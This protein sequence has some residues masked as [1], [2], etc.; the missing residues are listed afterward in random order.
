M[1]VIIF[2]TIS[3]PIG[4]SDCLFIKPIKVFIRPH[5]TV[6][7]TFVI[8]FCVSLCLFVVS[9][10]KCLNRTR[11]HSDVESGWTKEHCILRVPNPDGK[12]NF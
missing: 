11:R 10:A 7:A 8:A 1:L 3:F 4:Y 2:G 6:N 5:N 12:K 9:P